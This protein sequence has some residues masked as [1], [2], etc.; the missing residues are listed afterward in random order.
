MKITTHQFD[1]L[2]QLGVALWL[3]RQSQLTLI[4]I[5]SSQMTQSETS[6]ETLTETSL[7]DTSITSTDIASELIKPV[8]HLPDQTP[9]DLESNLNATVKPSQIS[10]INQTGEQ[11][12]IVANNINNAIDNATTNT[13]ILH[14]ETDIQAP[15][16]QVNHP[17]TSNPQSIKPHTSEPEKIKKQRMV[18]AFTLLSV[19]YKN[20][21]LVIHADDLNDANAS[22]LWQSFVSALDR[23]N[24]LA[25]QKTDVTQ[26]KQLDFPLLEETNAQ[27]LDCAKASVMGW[28]LGQKASMT[29][30][31]QITFGFLMT[32]KESNL[33][34]TKN[35]NQQNQ[36]KLSQ[37]SEQ[38]KLTFD[39]VIQA[40]FADHQNMQNHHPEM[41]V[42]PSLT[43]MLANAEYKKTLWQLL[44]GIAI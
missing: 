44:N 26:L 12:N 43:Q 28:L 1:V 37:D 9:V 14:T 2:Q 36:E 39:D 19:C 30:A 15:Q 32:L 11:D 22:Q 25:G 10:D 6:T 41:Q 24:Q 18:K 20:W 34:N 27:T 29:D 23:E 40:L 33:N 16:T 31:K 8:N 7:P 4:P 5:Q 38:N 42:L 17:E 3:P 35:Q 21:I 13:D